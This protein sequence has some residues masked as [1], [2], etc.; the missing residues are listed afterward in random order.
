MEWFAVGGADAFAEV[1]GFVA[2]LVEEGGWIGG[3]AFD[4]LGVVAADGGE[5]LLPEGADVEDEGGLGGVLEVDAVV[6]VNSPRMPR[7]AG[8]VGLGQLGPEAGGLD[9]LRRRD[10]I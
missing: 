7:L 6:V 3:A 8:H 2:E 9:Q 1:G 10:V 4:E 5:F